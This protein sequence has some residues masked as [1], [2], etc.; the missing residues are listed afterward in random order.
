MVSRVGD[1]FVNA[2]VEVVAVVAIAPLASLIPV[3]SLAAGGPVTVLLRLARVVHSKLTSVDRFLL[4]SLLCDNSA[5]D[6]GEVGVCETSR[7]SGTTVDGNP[8]VEHVLDASEKVYEVV[9]SIYSWDKVLL[10]FPYRSN[11][12]HSSGR[13]CCQ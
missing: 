3:G 7:L 13:T 2:L 10:E 11:P 12:C 8:D 1:Q 6:I 5:V 4:E 9:V